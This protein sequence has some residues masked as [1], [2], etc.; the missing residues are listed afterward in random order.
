MTSEGTPTP[1][2][3]VTLRSSMT[4]EGTPTPDEPTPTPTDEG[5]PTPDEWVTL[6][7]ASER[8]DVAVGTLRRWYG[9]GKVE[10]RLVPGPTGPRRLVNLSAVLDRTGRRPPQLP[11]A[12]TPPAAQEATAAQEAPP[13]TPPGT[14]LIPLDSWN[15]MMSQLANL[16]SAGQELADAR[17]AA[18]RFEERYNFEQERRKDEQERRKAAEA[19]IAELEEVRTAQAPLPFA[20]PPGTGTMADEVK[21]THDRWANESEDL[22]DPASPEA[23]KFHERGAEQPEPEPEVQEP[24]ED[25]KSD[26]LEGRPPPEPKPDE[27]AQV[28]DTIQEAQWYENTEA[29]E[30][31]PKPPWWVR[32]I[33][34]R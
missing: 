10:S 33:R 19:R 32:A 25:K 21:D 24:H 12:Y 4:S 11:A 16:H 7:I 30:P 3:W 18:G 23:T 27:L 31:E 20:G 34:R 13:A 2:E 17:E 14:M 1:D 5:T 8:A 29:P 6:R 28:L 22:L 9:A 26:E 15:T